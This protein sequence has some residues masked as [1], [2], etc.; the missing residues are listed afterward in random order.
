MVQNCPLCLKLATGDPAPKKFFLSCVSY[1]QNI[2]FNLIARKFS[3]MD[4]IFGC[5]IKFGYKQETLVDQRLRLA[6][7]T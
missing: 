3:C 6:S 4:K 1:R 2:C 5:S 7:G